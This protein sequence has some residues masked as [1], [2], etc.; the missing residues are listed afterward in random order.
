MQAASDFSTFLRIA[1]ICIAIGLAGGLLG[2]II[3]LIFRKASRL[4]AMIPGA[5]LFILAILA[6]IKA[7]FFS[8][9]WDDLAYAAVAMLCGGAA[10]VALV[11][12]LVIFLVSRRKNKTS[13][14]APIEQTNSQS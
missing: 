4:L 11:A 6:V 5:L 12:G 7:A 14:Q 1:L 2:F 9:G 10:I 3:T 13:A 8:T